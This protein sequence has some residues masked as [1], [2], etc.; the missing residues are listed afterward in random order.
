MTRKKS[1]KFTVGICAYNE[2]DNI[3]RLLKT[4]LNQDLP[5]KFILDEIIVV[6]S[7]C[8]DDTVRI[9]KKYEKKDSRVKLFQQTK[10]R[11]KASAINLMLKKAKNKIIVQSSADVLPDKKALFYL[12]PNILKPKVALVGPRI[13]PKNDLDTFMGFAVHLS[14][15]LHDR[16]SLQFPERPKVGELIVY[17][18]VFERIP[19]KAVVDEASVEPL[20]YLQGYRSVYCPQ[21]VVYNFGST[22]IRDF[23]S[24]RRRNFAG[25]YANKKKYGYS[26]VTLSNF[27]V[28]GVFLANMDWNLKF[29]VFSLG[30]ALMEMVAR[31]AGWLDVQLKLRD[32]SIWKVAQSS[33]KI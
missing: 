30:T 29:M 23:L 5:K 14:W 7:G 6:A 21:A 8:V 13:V 12:L 25:H 3:G 22:K 4:F 15:K 18:K 9:V 20:I 27:R 24:Q 31:L 1:V 10:R 28:L 33:K 26:V 11:G 16:I 19:A 2:A 32:H 17:K